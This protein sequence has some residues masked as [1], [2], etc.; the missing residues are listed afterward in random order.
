MLAAAR[1]VGMTAG[2]ALAA[3]VFWW[4]P[5]HTEPVSLSIAAALGIVAAS[6]SL[7]RSAS[8]ARRRTRLAS[9]R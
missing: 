9:R 1:Q 2:A 4:I 5:S 8:W 7:P 3:V 6:V